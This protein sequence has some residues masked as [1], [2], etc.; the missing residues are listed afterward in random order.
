[1]KKKKWITGVG[2]LLTLFFVGLVVL[3]NSP[4]SVQANAWIEETSKVVA[5]YCR[6]PIDNYQLDFY[7][8][9]S[10]DWLPWQWGEGVANIAY[11]A[12]YLITC[13]IWS[14]N[15]ALSYL[16]GY[17]VEQAYTLDFVSQVIDA[18][19]KN[20]QSLAGVDKSG[21]KNSGLFPSLVP[22]MI[23]ALGAYVV[24]VGMLKKQFQ[25]ALSAVLIFTVLLVCSMGFIAYA[26]SYLGGLNSF[27]QEFNEEVLRIGTKMSMP[28]LGNEDTPTSASNQKNNQ[29]PETLI[30]DMLFDIQ[31]KKPYLILQYDTINENEIGKDRVDK[32]LEQSPYDNDNDRGEIA[33]KEVENEKNTNMGFQ[34]VP[35][36]LG[37][38]LLVSLLNLVIDICVLILSGIMIYA[39]IMFIMYAMFLVVGLVFALIPGRQKSALNAS[40]KVLNA[41]LTKTGITLILTVT[42]SISMMMY[43]LTSSSSF[44]WM[45]FI[46]IVVFVAMLFKTS[47][48][49]GYM[50]LQGEGAKGI[51]GFAK[52][53]LTYGAM[54]SLTGR[55][56]RGG[57]SRNNTERTKRRGESKRRRKDD[58][59]PHAPQSKTESLGKRYG[60][61]KDLKNKPGELKDTLKKT[62]ENLKGKAKEGLNKKKNE[63]KTGVA[64]REIELHKKRAELEKR[65]KEAEARRREQLRQTTDRM[66]PE[67]L[68]DGKQAQTVAHSNLDRTLATRE[69]PKVT[70]ELE[71]KL[72]KQAKEERMQPYKNIANK[73]PEHA[74]KSEQTLST[75]ERQKQFVKHQQEKN[76]A[77]ERIQKENEHKG[78]ANR[79]NYSAKNRTGGA[80]G[81]TETVRKSENIPELLNKNWLERKP[82]KG[83]DK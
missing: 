50:H 23:L 33:K 25:K 59:S 9:T 69:L 35:N 72:N 77:R 83:K 32:L 71:N 79:G 76:Q 40:M 5:E 39:Q 57:A 58:T 1:M 6:F 4:V 67:G 82:E 12:L 29:A 16:V 20:M 74:K 38:V 36:R 31:I 15:V 11:Y 65:R 47:E 24:W 56:R 48:L 44:F 78:N 75:S 3:T 45:M 10:W 8:D 52:S 53:A 26:D 7:V 27:S 41:L 37:M 66:T 62:P 42:M 28:N 30:R 46:Q 80:V 55:R 70:P 61:L 81:R 13:F 14:I 17:I 49:L 51:T 43:S 54:R 63:F 68:V 34:K 2:I 60:D 64:N 73:Y 21:F 19:S 22:L 18:L